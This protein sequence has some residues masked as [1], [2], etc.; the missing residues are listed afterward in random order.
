MEK[1]ISEIRELF[2]SSR[3][4]SGY[5]PI[6]SLPTSA[7]GWVFRFGDGEYGVAIPYNGE[8]VNEEFNEVRLF[9]G[10]YRIGD[11]FRQLLLVTSGNEISREQFALFCYSL[12]NPGKDNVLRNSIEADPVEW[13]K[14]WKTLLGNTSVEKKPYAVI[15]EMIVLCQI[16]STGVK[17]AWGGPSASSK[18]I[19][20]PD[21]EYEVKSTTERYG[22]KVRISSQFQLKEGEKPVYLVF[23]RFEH[24]GNGYSIDDVAGILIHSYNYPEELLESQLRKIGYRKDM[25]AR[26]EKFAL[27]EQAVYTVDDHFPLIAEKSFK[28]GHIP[29]GIIR[30]DYVVEL[31]SCPGCLTRDLNP[32]WNRENVQTESGSKKSD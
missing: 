8:S 3:N 5:Y 1:V 16:L 25:S 20:T 31:D 11:E 32:D 9:T 7:P 4:K 12:V 14:E 10:Q 21:A 18:D 28:D 23:N 19:E 13:W 2:A 30:I 27:I 24:S 17:A 26:R 29:S 15:G 6:Q 22:K